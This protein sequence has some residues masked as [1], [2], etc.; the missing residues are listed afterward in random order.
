MDLSDIPIEVSFITAEKIIR[1]GEMNRVFST[2]E[3]GNY[4]F[5]YYDKSPFDINSE[6]L[7]AMKVNFIDRRP[8]KEDIVEIGYFSWKDTNK[9]YPIAT[10]RAWNWQQGCMLQWLGPD[11]RKSIVY[12]DRLSDSFVT[13]IMNVESGEKTILPMAYYTIQSTGKTA[14]CIDFERHYWF[15][16]G[17]S[18]KGIEVKEKSLPDYKEDGIW[19]MD[20]A[21]KTVRKIVSIDTIMKIQ[22]H[23]SMIRVANYLEH[24]MM[25]PCNEKFAFLHRWRLDDGGIYSRLFTANIDGSNI[26]LQ[27]DSGRMSHYCWKNKRKI[28]AWGAMPNR[29]DALRKNRSMVK[30]F[31]KPLLPLYRKMVH[32]GTQR[33]KKVHRAITNESYIEFDLES[34]RQRKIVLGRDDTD[35]HPSFGKKEYGHMMISDTYPDKMT[36]KQKLLMF[37]MKTGM[38]QIVDELPHPKEYYGKGYRCD[39]HPKWSTDSNYLSIDTILDGK[40]RMCVYEID[41]KSV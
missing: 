6:R 10:T 25:S 34:E 2:P 36:H 11:Y 32:S 1:K 37:N 14:L 19:A 18:Y 12:N 30:Y 28:I 4:F 31:V 23:T 27:S 22:P 13:V 20:I 17:Y 38:L 35:G 3:N 15:R 24:L 9:F 41:D 16:P 40:R 39:L 5:G 21:N 26:R 7:L 8:T 33:S 29:L